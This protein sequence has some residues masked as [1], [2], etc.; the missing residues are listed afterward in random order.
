M[1]K[2]NIET[3][4]KKKLLRMDE[5]AFGSLINEIEIVGHDLEEAI[6]N[7]PR[8][9]KKYD[10][11]IERLEVLKNVTRAIALRIQD[12]LQKTTEMS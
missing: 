11:V 10:E 3:K 9:Q 12:G 1:N 2:M 7:K 6:N 5:D 4:W 8:N